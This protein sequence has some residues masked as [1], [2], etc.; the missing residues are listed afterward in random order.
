MTQKSVKNTGVIS[1]PL[2]FFYPIGNPVSF[3]NEPKKPGS[4]LYP[5][6]SKGRLIGY[7]EELLSYRILAK[8]GRLVDTKSVQFLEFSPEE[9]SFDLDDDEEFEIIHENSPPENPIEVNKEPAENLES[10]NVELK[11]E[12]DND[13]NVDLNDGTSH[14]SDDSDD[15]ISNLLVPTPSNCV[16]QER[17]SR[18]RPEKYSYLTGDPTSFKNAIELYGMIC[19]KYLTPIPGLHGFFE[20]NQPPYQLLKRKKPDYVS[21]DSCN[22]LAKAPFFKLKNSLYGLK[23]APANWFNTLTTWLKSINFAQSSSDPCLFSHK[24]GD[25]FVFFHVDDLIV[26]GK[27]DVFE[28]LFLLRFP[29]SSAQDPDTLLGMELHQNLDSITLLQTKLIRK[30]LL[31]LGMQECKPV[32]T[33]LSPGIKLLA[34]TKEE[35]KEF[36]KLNINYRSHTG[37]LNF[38]SCRTR[39]DLAPAVSM[40]SGFNNNPGIKQ[41]QQI[42]HCWR[43][44]KG[45]MDLKLT[46]QPD[47]SGTICFWKSCPIAWNSKK[48]KNIALSST[49]AYLKALSD[50]FQENQW[51]LYLIEELWKEKLNPS[52]FNIDNSRLLKKIKNFG[53]NSKTKHLD[54]KMKWLRELKN[55]NQINVK[56]ISSEKMVADALTKASNRDSLRRLQHWCFLVLVSLS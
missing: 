16:L 21:K 5:K 35:K 54:I 38:L 3:L 27:V 8:D 41:W 32:L 30:G 22:F 34:P 15:E 44:L 36:S 18:I 45:T 39:P 11:E 10:K 52:E 49:E 26:A 24:D 33:P 50:G 13:I 6:G 23:Q 25:S 17:T 42:L 51:I 2:Y 56:L 55:S 28:D 1:I 4:K 43:Y 9:K 31:L 14:N 40:L 19:L 48:Q 7:N 29:N 20:Q 12:S 47:S 37:L 53:S 46:L